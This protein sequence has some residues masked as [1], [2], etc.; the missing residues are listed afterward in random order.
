M[1]K[2][3]ERKFLV[4]KDQL[5]KKLPPGRVIIQGYLNLDPMVRIRFVD[6]KGTY[7]A[8][9]ST[10]TLVRDEFEYPIPNK[11][12]KKMLLLCKKMTY[13]IRRKIDGWEV[14]EF[15]VPIDVYVA[16]C[17][18]SK[19]NSR[20]PSMPNWLGPEVTDNL[21]FYNANLACDIEWETDEMRALHPDLVG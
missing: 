8:I 5:P 4:L 15:K 7:L 3:I 1:A 13:K 21:A 20:L 2:E 19:A 9:K 11:D 12:A 17:E 16:E 10:G 6:G 18:L 14:D